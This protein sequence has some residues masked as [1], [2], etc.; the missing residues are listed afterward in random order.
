MMVCVVVLL[1]LRLLLAWAGF[2]S[3]DDVLF[4]AAFADSGLVL[5]ARLAASGF[6]RPGV[7][8]LVAQLSS[9]RRYKC[10]SRDHSYTAAAAAAVVGQQRIGWSTAAPPSMLW[11]WSWWCPHIR[12]FILIVPNLM[13][14]LLF[15][16]VY[17]Y[18]EFLE[19]LFLSSHLNTIINR[20]NISYIIIVVPLQYYYQL[21][22]C[23]RKMAHVYWETNDSTWLVAHNHSFEYSNSFIH[24]FKIIRV[25]ECSLQWDGCLRVLYIGIFWSCVIILVLL[26]QMLHIGLIKSDQLN[27]QLF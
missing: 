26:G 9:W 27:K 1:L 4:F 15:R 14:F 3:I 5:D 10:R 13:L 12:F 25:F 17:F 11:R 6:T 16:W 2:C 18:V 21:N 19:R 7:L 24:L 22:E 23:N 20:K 8:R